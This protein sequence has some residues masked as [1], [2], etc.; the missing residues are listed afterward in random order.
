[1]RIERK[2]W[3]VCC[4][5]SIPFEFYRLVLTII[6]RHQL[7]HLPPFEDATRKCAAFPDT[8]FPNDF[9]TWRGITKNTSVR[10]VQSI[11]RRLKSG[12]RLA[13][14]RANIKVFDWQKY[15]T[16]EWNGNENQLTILFVRYEAFEREYL[17]RMGP[18]LKAKKWIWMIELMFC[19]LLNIPDIYLTEYVLLGLGILKI[20]EKS[21]GWESGTCNVFLNCHCHVTNPFISQNFKTMLHSPWKCSYR[22][23]IVENN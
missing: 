5:D 10:V 22:A 20:C 2:M 13:P 16:A 17:S 23:V 19:V 18:T 8:D 11:Q 3:D 6:C 1:M 15:Q 21:H 12:W 14:F 4:T 7:I 9:Y